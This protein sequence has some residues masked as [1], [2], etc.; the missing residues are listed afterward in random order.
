MKKAFMLIAAIA[1]M[2]APVFAQDETAP[3]PTL[4]SLHG[5]T[6]SVEFSFGDTELGDNA[7]ASFGSTVTG[8]T[9]S[10]IKASIA[11]DKV[12]AGATISLIPEVTLNENDN[13][14]DTDGINTDAYQAAIDWYNSADGDD[15]DAFPVIDFEATINAAYGGID[16]AIYTTADGFD[17]DDAEIDTQAEWLDVKGAFGAGIIAQIKANIIALDTGGLLAFVLTD[18]DDI[19]DNGAWTQ[20]QWDDIYND[21]A[22]PAIQFDAST[23]TAAQI[24]T[25]TASMNALNEAIADF[26]AA[27]SGVD[28]DDTY[29]TAFP[30]S[31]AYF[32]LLGIAGVVDVEFILNGK[33]T[34]VG[35]KFMQ[36][37][38][39]DPLHLG[40]G[41]ALTKGVV[42]GL[43][44]SVMYTNLP[45]TNATSEDWTTTAVED[46]SADDA[47]H[48]IQ[49]NAGYA[50]DMFNFS[51]D[52]AVPNLVADTPEVWFSV[53]GGV[54]L[55]DI[56]GLTADVEFTKMDA[57]NGMGIAVGAGASIMGI[58]PSVDF[59]YHIAGDSLTDSMDITATPVDYDDTTD[60]GTALDYFNSALASNG[61]LGIGLTVDLA[62]LMGMKLITVDGGFAMVFGGGNDWN[63]GLSFDLTDLFA[64]VTVGF[65]IDS[66]YDEARSW[67]ASIGAEFVGIT[68]G[69]TFGNDIIAAADDETAFSFGA[70]LGYTYDV[71]ALT[72]AFNI[73]DDADSSDKADNIK[74]FSV[75]A[76]VSF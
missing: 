17:V 18:I 40:M 72:A 53:A 49:I 37:T 15:Y 71:V 45:A 36:A 28:G 42:E 69:L 10:S 48:A 39:D 75:T 41:L 44:A 38:D 26:N 9:T 62:D 16:G 8:S 63:A 4:G 64:P 47:E 21:A 55:A 29:D 22:I 19:T 73:A 52:F 50:T 7:G 51:A 60:D 3:A 32:R 67:N 35:N 11:T 25:A 70:S 5:A 20:D 57:D 34:S 33:N 56:A 27:Y 24:V 76:K 46:A 65:G 6:G 74:S 31:N 30:V 59:R 2:A 66:A 43:S 14:V 68:A 1:M 13:T 58:S 61:Y 12:E 54:S 23:F